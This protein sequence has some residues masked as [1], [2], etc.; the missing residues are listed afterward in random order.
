MTSESLVNIL[1][2]LAEVLQS[3][4]T[5]GAA[6]AGIAEAATVS[7]PGCDAASIATSIS[8]RPSTAAITARIAL[9]LDIVQYDTRPRSL[10]HLVRNDAHGTGKPGRRRRCLSA[11]HRGG[12]TER[13]SG[14]P[15]D[16]L[17]MGRRNSGD[18]EH[19]QPNGPLRRVRCL[20][21]VDPCRAGGHCR[22]PVSRV[23]SVVEEAQRNS[24]D[25]ADVNLATGLL[26]VSEACTAEQ[27]EGCSS[28]RRRTTSRRS[29]R[30]PSGSSGNTGA[31]ADTTP[32]C[33]EGDDARGPQCPTAAIW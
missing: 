18:V 21:R 12:T 1:Q 29:S 24:E 28:R 5:L 14:G 26:M 33:P 32:A 20:H 13:R 22:Q 4:R 3:Q 16:A 31:L 15:V 2:Q 25:A 10:P 23:R 8:G 30:S 7:V 6:L 19:V 17:E 27:A 9:E 11:L